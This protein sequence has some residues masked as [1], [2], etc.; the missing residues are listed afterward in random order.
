MHHE[1]VVRRDFQEH[2][3]CKQ[4]GCAVFPYTVIIVRT[5][6]ENSFIRIHVTSR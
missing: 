5:V 4:R 3:P 2:N 1:F 6:L